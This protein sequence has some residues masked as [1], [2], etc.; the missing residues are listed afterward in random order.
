LFAH[1]LATNER[2]AGPP[3]T[4]VEALTDSPHHTV[5]RTA[6]RIGSARLIVVGRVRFE[7][8]DGRT[9]AVWK[10]GRPLDHSPRLVGTVLP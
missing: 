5:G 6:V 10:R 1:E 2:P 3:R 8:A 7:H 9:R 4:A